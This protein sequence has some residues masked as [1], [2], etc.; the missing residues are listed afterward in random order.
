[1]GTVMIEMPEEIL[2][3]GN[4]P[5]EEASVEIKKIVA[6]E[7]Y[8]EGRVS[9]GKASE[10]AGMCLADFMDL[11]A[12]RDIPINYTLQNWKDDLTWIKTGRL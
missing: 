4:I 1:M 11:I 12:E 3:A 2:S 10:M 6:L 7:L 9:I 5:K 8:R